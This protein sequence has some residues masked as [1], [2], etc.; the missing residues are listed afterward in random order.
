MSDFDD[1]VAGLSIDVDTVDG[2]I[3]PF[4]E[5]RLAEY[6]AELVRLSDAIDAGKTL[7]TLCQQ[8]E[9]DR[10]TPLHVS[11]LLLVRDELEIGRRSAL[12]TRFLP[13]RETR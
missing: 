8:H 10:G 7:V 2:E 6:R 5:L 12:V 1:V 13:R 9:L 3:A 4:V 11:E